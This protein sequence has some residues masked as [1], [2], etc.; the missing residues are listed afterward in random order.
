MD[1]SLDTGDREIVPMT[2]GLVPSWHKGQAKEV[3]Y[4][5]NNCRGEGMLERASFKRPFEKGQR[6]VVLVDG[7]VI[8]IFL[9]LVSCYQLLQ[10]SIK[11]YALKIVENFGFK[12]GG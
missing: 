12:E 2:W 3:A 11:D 7:W 1:A 5:M 9:S 4:K 8:T 10:K 6:C